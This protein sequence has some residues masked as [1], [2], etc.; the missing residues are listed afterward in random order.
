[1]L[2]LNRHY[3]SDIF[4]YILYNKPFKKNTY[5][6]IFANI[7]GER[8]SYKTPKIAYLSDIT[9]ANDYTNIFVQGAENSFSGT[10]KFLT[11]HNFIP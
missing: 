5:K 11:N 6:Y 7:S 3:L 8:F 1:M 2:Q 9:A 10:Q 4:R